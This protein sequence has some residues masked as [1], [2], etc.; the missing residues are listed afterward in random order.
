MESQLRELLAAELRNQHGYGMTGV[1]IKPVHIANALF[2]EEHRLVGKMTDLKL[3]MAATAPREAAGDRLDAVRRMLDK[4]QERWGRLGEDGD[5]K[6]STLMTRLLPLLRTILGT[7]GAAFGKTPEMSSF[8]S[9]TALT[10]TRDP[11][12]EHAGEFVHRLWEFPTRVPLLSIL[13]DLTSPDREISLVDDLSA[14]L[15]PLTDGVQPIRDARIEPSDSPPSTVEA[16]LR[17]AATNLASYEDKVRPNPIASL[18]RIVLLGSMSVFRHAATRGHECKGLPLRTLLLDGSDSRTSIVAGVSEHSVSTLFEDAREYMALLLAS[19]LAEIDAG[20]RNDP[21]SVVA[22][23]FSRNTKQTKGPVNLKDLVEAVEE[24]RDGDPDV[25]LSVELP[26]RLVG[27]LGGDNTLDGYLRLLGL[28][29]GLLYPQQKNRI[30][31]LVPNDRTLEVLAISTFDITGQ[32]IEYRDFLDALFDTWGVIVGGRL[33][34]ALILSKAGTP[35]PSAE[36]TENSD[37]FLTRLQGLGLA[38]KMADSVA[39]VGLTESYDV[40]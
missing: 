12:D 6:R 32:P 8:S 31:R 20:W 5:L 10:V 38:R 27:L 24:L 34:D 33:E 40:E 9:P 22:E 25:D 7:D 17:Q 29:C 16:R 15:V 30:K 37:R 18:Q 14:V 39:V 3:L 21:E 23:L 4:N 11:S 36:L 13:H 28:R 1:K 19:R 26:R 2:R 35:V